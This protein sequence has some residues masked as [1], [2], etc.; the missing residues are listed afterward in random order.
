MHASLE[1]ERPSMDWVATG[2]TR[3][4]R[5]NPPRIRRRVANEREQDDLDEEVEIVVD[6]TRRVTKAKSQF[7]PIIS[8]AVRASST[9]RRPYPP[10]HT[11]IPSTP[12]PSPPREKPSSPADVN[13]SP[14]PARTEIILPL[15]AQPLPPRPIPIS[16]GWITNAI[17]SMKIQHVRHAGEA[18]MM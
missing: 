2:I 6:T 1:P 14:A 3:R 7:C 11:F 16:P 4:K 8:C 10:V 18:Q 13:S 12:W 9:A 15:H 17:C 5:T